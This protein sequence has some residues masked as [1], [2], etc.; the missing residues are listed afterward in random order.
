LE[1][2]VLLAK[3][4]LK[5]LQILII[6]SSVVI[7]LLAETDYAATENKVIIRRNQLYFQGESFI[8]RGIEYS[9]W[10]PGTG[11]G[12]GTWPEKEQ[13]L[14]DLEMIQ[15]LGCNVVSVVDPPESFFE[16]IEES[17]LLVIY[18][19]GI[20]QTQCE[21]FGSKDFLAKEIQFLGVFERHKNNRRIFLWVLGREVTP[22]AQKKHGEKIAKWFKDT[23]DKM[24]SG[25]PGILI[26][27][28]NWPPTRSLKLDSPDIICFDLYP[29]WPPEVSLTGFGKYIRDILRPLARRRPLLIT[30]FGV[31]SIEVS[32]EDQGP[33]L[34]KCWS[35]LR[36]AGA[37]GAVVFS[38]MDEWWKNYNS[39]IS[40]NAWWAREPAPK[41]EKT[42]DL[43]PEEHYG[44][45]RADRKPKLAY[46]AVKEMFGQT[47][48][49]VE[50]KSR[51]RLVIVAGIIFVL[52]LALLQIWSI[53]TRKQLKGQEGGNM[54]NKFKGKKSGFTLVELLVVI[55]I[56]ALLLG[57]VVPPL[58]K[59]RERARRT[60]CLSNLHQIHLAMTMYADDNDSELPTRLEKK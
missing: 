33:L 60:V 5:L 35:E 14:K 10:G 21:N 40:K 32:L 48:V 25:A 46:Y 43:D 36:E 17:N 58:Q 13:I 52:F 9:P 34:A 37:C 47:P 59:A 41:D 7:I 29:G 54:E 23:V 22:V 6:A 12:K 2:V 26:S 19:L 53:R 4:K 1:K 51:L 8:V 39:P 38:F 55:A 18:T 45:V 24:R 49:R 16:A 3:S 20:F 15:E 28:A 56:I 31:N 30:E 11:P 50:R 44:L 27:H 42:H 57:I